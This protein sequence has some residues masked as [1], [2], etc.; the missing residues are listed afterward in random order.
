M[1]YAKNPG[2][3][4]LEILISLLVFM[5]GAVTLLNVLGIGIFSISAVERRS[6]GI[7]LNNRGMEEV[8]REPFENIVSSARTPVDWPPVGAGE[9]AIFEREAVVSEI[10]PGLKQVTDIAY[11]RTKGREISTRLT[12]FVVIKD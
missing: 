10:L 6:Q 12:T 5:V 2:F 11:Y 7:Y 8:S 3:T 4:F 9:P 1:G